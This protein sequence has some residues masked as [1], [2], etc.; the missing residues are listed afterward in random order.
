MGIAKVRGPSRKE[1]SIVLLLTN[2]QKPSSPFGRP[3]ST[4]T[5][6]TNGLSSR[7]NSR[8]LPRTAS[9]SRLDRRNRALEDAVAPI[10]PSSGLRNQINLRGSQPNGS[11]FSIR[12]KATFTV[13]AQNF[14]PGTTAADIEAVFEPIASD[15]QC[16]IV[17]ARPTVICEAVTREK[18]GAEKIVQTFNNKMVGFTAQSKLEEVANTIVGGRSQTLRL[19]QGFYKFSVVQ[20]GASHRP[21]CRSQS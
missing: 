17:T 2:L 18:E 11:G 15:I 4:I 10:F 14:A 8:P 3:S 12:G 6:S 9:D 19:H 20:P 5:P 1:L 7:L 13:V 21:T 16:K